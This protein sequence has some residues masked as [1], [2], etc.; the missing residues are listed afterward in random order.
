MII[1][2]H[3]ISGKTRDINI[4]YRSLIKRFLGLDNF[5]QTHTSVEAGVVARTKGYKNIPVCSTVW[6]MCN[7]TSTIVTNNDD[8]LEVS[9]T[10]RLRPYNE[11]PCL[12][13]LVVYLNISNI[14]LHLAFVSKIDTPSGNIY[15]SFKFGP[16][17]VVAEHLI[18][19]VVYG[20]SVKYIVIDVKEEDKSIYFNNRKQVVRLPK[21]PRGYVG[22]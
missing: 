2:N 15:V 22:I 11:T 8:Y 7:I 3:N 20:N 4:S 19:D 13:D 16:N 18:D 17:G 10:R 1:N 12:G 9:Y 6:T 14:I 5:T 21:P